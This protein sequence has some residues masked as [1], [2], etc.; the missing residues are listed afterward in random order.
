MLIHWGLYD[1]ESFGVNERMW[2]CKEYY[3][4]QY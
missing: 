1:F 3:N 4:K 2:K